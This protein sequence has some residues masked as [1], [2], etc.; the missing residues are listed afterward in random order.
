MAIAIKIAT[1]ITFTDYVTTTTIFDIK[2]S[3]H[4]KAENPHHKLVTNLA[5]ITVSTTVQFY[6]CTVSITFTVL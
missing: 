3:L 4:H 5:T 1:S 6:D 2:I